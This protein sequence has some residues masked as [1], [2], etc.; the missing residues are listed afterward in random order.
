MQGDRRYNQCNS[1]QLYF[2]IHS[3]IQCFVSIFVVDHLIKLIIVLAISVMKKTF[4]ILAI[5]TLLYLTLAILPSCNDCKDTKGMNFTLTAIEGVVKKI[6]GII[7]SVPYQILYY[8]VETYEPQP[9]GIR[10]DSVGIELTNVFDMYSSVRKASF[11]N[12]AFACDPALNFE[13]INEISII[14]SEDYTD[15]FPKG[16]NLKEII[17]IRDG[18]MVNN[19]YFPEL[20]NSAKFLTFDFAPSENRTHNLTIK[21]ILSN[22]RQIETTVQGL[23]INN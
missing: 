2:R 19:T 18:Y 6:T 7:V 14:S 4:L 13:W 5:G 23:T 22:G 17:T 11:F 1:R 10:Y 9:I 20:S 3:D 16:T 15:L 8:T 12:Q 21:Y